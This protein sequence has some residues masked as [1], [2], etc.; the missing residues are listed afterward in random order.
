MARCAV[1]SPSK[2]GGGERI[3]GNTRQDVEVADELPVAEA[4]WRRL[5]VL[6][7]FP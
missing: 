5:H 3:V 6:F 2:G 4:E 7:H 1:V